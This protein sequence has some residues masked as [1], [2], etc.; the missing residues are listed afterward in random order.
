MGATVVVYWPGITEQQQDEQPPLDDYTWG[1][2]MAERESEPDVLQA[3]VDLGAEPIL[4]VTT[5]GWEDDD[6]MWVAPQDLRAAAR[7]LGQ[8]VRD[9]RPGVGR[10]LEVYGRHAVRDEPVAEQFLGD[11][12]D[13]AAIATWAEE[14]G[15]DRMTLYVGW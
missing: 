11:L 2:W 6:V 5:D 1:N 9:D 13:I 8:A 14:Q 4:T 10:I 12:E 3:I 7:R 15:T